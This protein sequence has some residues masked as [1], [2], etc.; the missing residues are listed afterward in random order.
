MF[1]K[2]KDEYGGVEDLKNELKNDQERDG[3]LQEDVLELGE[4]GGELM[5]VLPGQK[6]SMGSSN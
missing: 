6:E 2:Q 1:S 5:E 3:D 4:G